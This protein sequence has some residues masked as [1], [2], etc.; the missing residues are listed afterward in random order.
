MG[1]TISTAGDV[2]AHFGDHRLLIPAGGQYFAALH[3]G[4]FPM[5][6]RRLSTVRSYALG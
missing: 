6:T 3:S 5:V 1:A 2:I 4:G